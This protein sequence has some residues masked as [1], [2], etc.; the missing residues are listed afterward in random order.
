MR[1]FLELTLD[2]YGDTQ[3]PNWREGD[4]LAGKVEKVSEALVTSGQK[5]NDIASFRRIASSESSTFHVDRLHKFV[6]S[7]KA[8]PSPTELRKG[9]DEVQF[10]FEV[11]W[12]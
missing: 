4:K 6:H 11:I 10:V 2:H 5:K 9:W 7:R 3:M 8:L 1:V 12:S